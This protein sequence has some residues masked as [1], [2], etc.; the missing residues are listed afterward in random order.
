[1]A[2]SPFFEKS[3]F[4]TCEAYRFESPDYFKDQTYTEKALERYQE[5]LDDFPTSEYSQT[6]TASMSDLRNKLAMKL[7]ETGILYLKMDEFE[8]ARMSFNRVLDQ[9]YDTDIVEKVH[10]GVIQSF[11]KDNKL[12]QAK[13]YWLDKGSKDI[14]NEALISEIDQLFAKSE[15]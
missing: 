3:R 7:Y 1:M 12:E 15:K 8:P 4:R 14:V 11:V 9:Y 5:F 6:V 13:E 10:F 2:F